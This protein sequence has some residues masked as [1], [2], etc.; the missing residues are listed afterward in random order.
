MRTMC[1]ENMLSKFH[2]L[3][4]FLLLMHLFIDR[5]YF[6][7]QLLRFKI[8]DGYSFSFSLIN[9]IIMTSPIINVLVKFTILLCTLLFMDISITLWLLRGDKLLK[10]G[11]CQ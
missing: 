8:V 7:S 3:K 5:Y 10:F 1:E 9:D 11:F 6:I 4:F 2:S